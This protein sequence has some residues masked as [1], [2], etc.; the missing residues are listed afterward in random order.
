MHINFFNSCGFF[1][2]I[3]KPGMDTSQLGRKLEYEATPTGSPIGP[4]QLY[5]YLN[6]HMPLMIAIATMSTQSLAVIIS[7]GLEKFI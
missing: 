3:Y 1:H 2:F 7:A 5:M 4:F 6:V